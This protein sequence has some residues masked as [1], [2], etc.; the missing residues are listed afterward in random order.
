MRLFSE[1]DLLL[2]ET[3]TEKNHSFVN[4][5]DSVADF[6]SMTE[7]GNERKLNSEY[8][9][10]C[11]LV[12]HT[13]LFYDFRKWLILHMDYTYGAFVFFFKS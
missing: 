6:N 9:C 1:P 8:K 7:W 13:N 2:I 11:C 4:E 12:H 5:T 10:K 3:N